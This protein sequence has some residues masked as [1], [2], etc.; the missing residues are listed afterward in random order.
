MRFGMRA[1]AIAAALTLALAGCSGGGSNI[2]SPGA[3]SSGTPPGGG[4]GGTGGGGT[5]GGSASCPTGTTNAG[6]LGAFT[7]CSL[8]GEVL[9]NLTLPVVS[10]VVYRLSGRVDIGRD[11]GANGAQTGGQSATLTISP[12]VTLF[13]DEAGDM[14]IV[15]RGSRIVAN[16]TVSQPIIFTSR[17]DVLG[18]N[19][20]TTANRQWGGVILLGRAPIKGCNT[21][22]ASGTVDCQNA[23]EGVTAATGR[24]ALY[25]GATA[26]DTSGSLQY[27]QVRYPGAFLTSATAGDDLNGITL[28]GVGSAT[29]I[30]NVQVHNSGDDGIEV[31]GGTVNL[32]HVV[33]TGAYDDSLD[34]DEGWTGKVQ[35]VVI[36]QTTIT[37]GVDKMIEASNRTVASTGGLQTNPTIAN[38][39]FVGVPL[40]GATNL[41]GIDVN[42]TSG[43]PGASTRFLNGVVTGSRICARTD[44]ATT[45]PAVQF[46]S[47]LFDCPTAVSSTT[48]ARIN[49][50]A[51][52]TQTIPNTLSGVLPGPNELARNA[53]AL[54]PTTVDSAFTAGTYVGAFSPT[55]TATSNWAAGWT[56]QLFATAGCPT[57]TTEGGTVAGARRCVLQGTVGSG[58]V[59]ASLRLTAGNIYEISGRVDVGVDV[60]GD[61][62][63]TGGV[64]GTLTI[65]AGVTLYGDGAADMLIVNRGSQI[66][67]N[68]T[69]ASPVIMTSLPDVTN[70]QADPINASRE[71]AGLIVLGR[72]QTKG[73]N[74]NVAQGSA[75]CQNAVEGVTAATGRAALY[76]GATNTDN[77]GRISYLQIRYPGAFLTS[78]TLGDDLN[79]LTLGAVGSGTVID[80]VQVHNSGDDGIEVFGGKANMKYVIITGAVDDSLDY[81]EGWTGNV[82]YLIITQ[83]ATGIAR[84]RLVEASN[85]QVASA[86]NAIQTKPLIANFTMVGVPTN[87]STQLIGID[88]NNTS[89]TPGSSGR[90]VNGVVTGSTTC[91]RTDLAATGGDAPTVNSTLLDCPGALSTASAATLAAGT[92]NSTATANT[93]SA[94]AA[95]GRPFI[96]GSAETARTAV[97][98]QTFFSDTFF[99]ATT[100]IGAVRDT[101]DTWWQSWSCGLA[102]GSSC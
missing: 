25:G 4:T 47:I 79:G 12:G 102:S 11:L 96:N 6:A 3:T 41:I 28:G 22:V 33:I 24:A 73:C 80:H 55:E 54:N 32:R 42:N 74:V 75:T 90:Y 10:G 84:D 94:A 17:E 30:D 77:S 2:A 52:N 34:Y 7:V 83:S 9:T 13:G 56:F 85:R 99:D 29:V 101:S 92:N 72:A 23:V 97:N 49:A 26:T 31:F 57:G 20:P 46:D 86:G 40:N 37:G 27:V 91:L 44:T 76:G 68:G 43:T 35:F 95:G 18:Q 19:D 88:M 1:R 82:Q 53:T 5:G 89:G 81:D 87:G 60:G 36:R 62:T 64:A 93:L 59:P 8:S 39:T 69:P 38:F 48:A 65:D 61:G 70:T 58:S 45:S 100:Y 16:G 51:N 50:G 78:A 71:W 14:L 66:F 21:A 63:A 15:N 67:V 98:P